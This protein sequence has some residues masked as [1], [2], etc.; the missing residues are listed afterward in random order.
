M[1]STCEQPAVDAAR[2]DEL[3]LVPGDLLS[4][5]AC[6]WI[7]QDTSKTLWPSKAIS[8]HQYAFLPSRRVPSHDLS[9]CLSFEC[10]GTKVEIPGVPVSIYHVQTFHRP[11]SH[12]VSGYDEPTLL[13]HHHVSSVLYA[14]ISQ[15][16]I[17]PYMAR[18]PPTSATSPHDFIQLPCIPPPSCCVT[19][20]V[21]RSTIVTLASS[22]RP[23]P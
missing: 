5:S 1:A 4:L 22:R 17:S 16:F 6:E 19:L 18:Q 10:C 12:L 13:H 7:V 21:E 2:L 9:L 3:A 20:M 11:Q 23:L 8:T 15:S 14:L